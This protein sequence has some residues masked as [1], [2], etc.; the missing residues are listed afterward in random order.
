MQLVQTGPSGRGSG[1]IFGSV[2]DTAACIFSSFIGGAG[3]RRPT[4]GN[5][6]SGGNSNSNSIASAYDFSYSTNSDG[7]YKI[8]ITPGDKDKK[9]CSYDIQPQG[10]S[11]QD[12]VSVAA[13]RCIQG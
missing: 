2:F 4:G 1:N 11:I 8:E 3:C 7:S 10:R 5:T 13:T 6:N 12:V 9:K